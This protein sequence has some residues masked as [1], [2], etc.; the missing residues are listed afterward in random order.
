[1]SYTV[2][3]YKQFRVPYSG[4]VSYPASQSGGSTPYSGY[5][6]VTVEVDV[7]VDTQPFD[8]SVAVTNQH[9]DG[10]TASV[11]ATESAEVVSIKENSLRVGNTIIQGFFN[12]VRFEI[13]SKIME[14]TKRIDSLLIDIKEKGDNLMK[15]K[16]QM[17]VDYRR[18]AER[19]GKIFNE[20]NTELENRVVALDQP[21]FDMT[22]SIDKVESRQLESD[23]ADLVPIA[24]K[25][26]A[27]LQTQLGAV[28]V[29]KRANQVLDDTARYIASK[30]ATDITIMRSAISDNRDQSFYAPFCYLQATNSSRVVDLS[31]YGNPLVSNQ[32]EPQL[33]DGVRGFEPRQSVEE[34]D[35]VSRFFENE[36]A[37]NY[38]SADVHS[39][40]V[41]SMIHQLFVNNK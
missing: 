16:N 17:E 34:M 1:M 39:D 5:E 33:R 2:K 32:I 38:E 21:I 13:S 28:L 3:K 22:R 35:Q 31:I 10:L 15:L 11:V 4:R 24:G 8:H 41:K 26:N 7:F 14:L 9:V 27:M 6:D 29:K 19:Y 23:L 37:S 30:Q 40:R 25:E 20:L 36:L 18:T 12:T